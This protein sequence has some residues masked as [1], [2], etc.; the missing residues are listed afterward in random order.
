VEGE[1]VSPTPNDLERAFRPL[2]EQVSVL[3]LD[4][5]ARHPANTRIEHGA[6]H[7]DVVQNILIE[8]E[9]SEFTVR[10]RVDLRRSAEER[11]PVFVLTHVGA[12]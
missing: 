8:D 5:K 10:G 11:R 7:W 2:F 4:A 6:D 3:Q 12:E 9:V 1:T